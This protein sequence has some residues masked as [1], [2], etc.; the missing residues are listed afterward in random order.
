[1]TQ[2]SEVAAL[3]ARISAECSAA[4]RALH[5]L[6]AGSARHDFITARMERVGEIAEQIVSLVGAKAATPLIAKAME[7]APP[8]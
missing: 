3:M 1:M 6:S 4:E 8:S 2:R 7:D 5:G